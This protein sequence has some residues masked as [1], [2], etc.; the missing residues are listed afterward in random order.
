MHRVYNEGRCVSNEF[1]NTN[2]QQ[3]VTLLTINGVKPKDV[4][5]C[6]SE[7]QLGIYFQWLAC[8]K[9]GLIPIFISSDF[10]IES[11][12]EMN[13][14]FGVRILLESRVPEHKIFQFSKGESESI[15][16]YNIEPGAVIHLT[17]STTGS[18]KLVVRT[19]NQLD[20]EIE[21]Y[22]QYLSI[23]NNDV[24]FPIVPICH[25]FGFIS[26]MLLSLKAN[27]K[28]MLTDTK[29]PRN[30]IRLSN[31]EKAT[32]ILGVPYFYRKMLEVSE[33]YALG[34][35]IRYIIASGGP[36]EAG[37]QDSFFERFGLELM[38]QYGSTETG[39]LCMGTS[40]GNHRI[41]GKP[42]PGVVIEI[43]DDEDGK[44]CIYVSSPTTTGGYITKEGIEKIDGYH[45]AIGDLGEINEFGEVEI[46]GRKDD[47]F[48][49]AGKKI[50]KNYVESILLNI[51]GVKS[52][53]VFLTKSGNSFELACEYDSDI[54]VNKNIFIEHCKIY[55]ATYQI[56][57]TFHKIPGLNAERNKTWKTG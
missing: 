48:I 44:P 2:V 34:N 8:V 39:S 15:C 26:G 16:S 1:Y 38:Q 46:I 7:H 41:V 19:K 22:A 13:K 12:T 55:L 6:K 57:K 40:K 21:R 17:S 9:M 10:S 54:E 4:I 11:I 37:L 27:T 42:I 18:P 5:I 14:E 56:P 24:I 28:L 30:I 50:D 53:R 3:I 29:L 36:M 49:I 25:S 35:H 51:P 33:S 23:D 20:A 45:Y 43:I 32:V 52:A 31:K 47:V